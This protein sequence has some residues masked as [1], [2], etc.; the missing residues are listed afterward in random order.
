[1]A[2]LPTIFLVHGV[3]LARG[4]KILAVLG[5]VEIAVLLLRVGPDA[6]DGAAITNLRAFG[7]VPRLPLWLE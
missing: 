3:L 1:V 5:I 4:G 6:D 7:M 2:L